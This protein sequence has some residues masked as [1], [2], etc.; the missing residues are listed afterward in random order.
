MSSTLFEIVEL[1]DG[2]VGLRRS[3]DDGEPLI[4]IRFS[5]EAT[6]YLQEGRF[7]VVKAMI[8]AGLEAAGDMEALENDEQ[9]SQL[10]SQSRVLH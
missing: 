3:G 7:E 6:D 10:D 2:C 4:S 9:E 1:A 8:E 5:P